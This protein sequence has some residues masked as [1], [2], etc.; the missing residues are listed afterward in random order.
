L[1]TNGFFM[2][3]QIAKILERAAR[4]DISNPRSRARVVKSL[5]R[6]NPQG[7][8][9]CAQNY[10]QIVADVMDI[11]VA[12]CLRIVGEHDTPEER[13]L[14]LEQTVLDW[15]QDPKEYGQDLEAM[16]DVLENYH[17]FLGMLADQRDKGLLGTIVR[18]HPQLVMPELF[19]NN[20]DDA[21]LNAIYAA[22]IGHERRAGLPRIPKLN[23]ARPSL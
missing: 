2:P 17:L 8:I 1:K 9:F 10:A 6:I 11:E 13:R 15:R 5:T 3:L 22:R 14:M 21:Q 16:G 20:L 7:A 23:T 18:E 4:T 19:H 12:D